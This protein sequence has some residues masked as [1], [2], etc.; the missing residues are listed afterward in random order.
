M[1]IK[2]SIS[3]RHI[4]DEY[5]MIVGSGSSL[6]YTQAVSL[7]DTAAYLLESVGQEPFEA[8]DWVELLMERYDGD[9]ETA[10][11]DVARLITELHEVKVLD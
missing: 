8:E 9:A 7:N 5:I 3:I 4:A 2:D 1:K 10:A 11:A 6:D